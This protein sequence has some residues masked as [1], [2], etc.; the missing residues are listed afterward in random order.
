VPASPFKVWYPV[1]LTCSSGQGRGY[2]E[3]GSEI[4]LAR[5]QP[6]PV[7]EKAAPAKAAAKNGG[8]QKSLKDMFQARSPSLTGSRSAL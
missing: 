1:A 5:V 6:Q 8:G 4:K 2:C 3:P 7:Q